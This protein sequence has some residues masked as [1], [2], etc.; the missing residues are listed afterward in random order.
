[1]RDE[2]EMDTGATAAGLVSVI[3]PFLKGFMGGVRDEAEEAGEAAGGKLRAFAA[4][5][6]RSLEPDVERT[7]AALQA[8]QE[9]ADQPDDEDWQAALRVQLR[10]LLEE[11]PALAEELA[12]TLDE[13]RR[14]GVVADVVI[15]GDIRADHGGVAAGRDISGD[16]HTSGGELQGPEKPG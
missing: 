8:A 4:R 6:W 1:V 13:G 2:R 15:H 5:I 10:K 3:A 7:P 9:V 12:S 14:E 11:D 16:L